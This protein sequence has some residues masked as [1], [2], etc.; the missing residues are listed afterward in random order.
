MQSFKYNTNANIVETSQG[1]IRGYFLNDVYTFKG[2]PYGQA[3]RFHQPEK[4]DP[5]DGVLDCTSFGFVCP[6][7]ETE[8]PAI[9]LCVPHRY[10]MMDEDCL[11]LNV[12][13]PG[14]DDK[15]R[16]VMVW[17][18]GGG[19]EGG[20]AIEH[21]AYDGDQM[22][23][24]GDVVVVSI[25]HRL[26]VLGYM[27]FSAFGEE[28]ENSGNAG[29]SDI[30]LAL[31]WIHDNV[32]AFGGDPENV[33][34]FGQ[35]GGGGKIITL[36]QMPEADGLYS[37]GMIMSGVC[38]GLLPDAEES[39][40]T[41]AKALM[42]D[43][44]I[45]TMKEL[46]EVPYYQLAE[47]FVR[48]RP[49]YQT[50]G[51][52]TG[53]VP[54]VNKH[55]IGDPLIHGF[56]KETSHI[57]LLVGSCFGE[58]L[59]FNR[60]EMDKNLVTKEEAEAYVRNMILT[61]DMQDREAKEEKLNHLIELFQ[62]AYPKRNLLD[63]LQ[64]DYVFRSPEIAFIRERSALNESTYSYMFDQDTALEEGRVPWHCADIPYVF[65]NTHMAPHTQQEGVEELEEKIF[66]AVMSFAKTSDPNHRGIPVWNPSNPEEEHI[67]FFAN[68]M[69][70]GVNTD[71]AL[72][73]E[74]AVQMKEAYERKMEETQIQH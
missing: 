46:E 23:R 72:I 58:F 9:E 19:Y 15:K 22:A 65:H 45:H 13:T 17:L 62:K 3:K 33:C 61:E 69:R 71:H 64:L 30:I 59:S 4:K 2:I 14:T 74:V 34:L 38:S 20:S 55:Y 53:C 70:T 11:N 29:M 47:A 32:T 57:P 63:L 21:L 44:K 66:Q 42:E 35:S 48:L 51:I 49:A 41:F 52:N 68:E 24:H 10:W 56:R 37:K 28:Y 27:D 1:K 73:R 39:G 60:A 50:K 8:K 12:W 6:L 54:F 36:L 43:L 18:H 67:M 40:E 31:R 5:W 26:N 7:L 25:N 16:P